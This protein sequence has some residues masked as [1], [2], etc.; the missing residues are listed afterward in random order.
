MIK[1]IVGLGNPGD[2]YA[3]TRHNAGFWFLDALA[4]NLQALPWRQEKKFFAVYSQASIA[5]MSLHLLKP[6]TFMNLSGK[7][8]AAIANFYR[9][10]PEE[11]LI[12]YDDLDFPAGTVKAKFSGG[13]GGHNGLRDVISA[14]DSRDFYRLRFGIGRPQDK[15]QVLNF[16]LHAPRKEEESK[17]LSAIE[18]GVITISK[19]F[20]AKGNFDPMAGVIQ[21]LNQ[22]QKIVR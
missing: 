8:L 21:T 10:K 5:G 13:H 11:I 4:N 18:L 2:E 14:L 9:L 22:G 15:S 3:K 6:Q 19:N 1:L 16:V 7:S 12:A 20:V 17:I